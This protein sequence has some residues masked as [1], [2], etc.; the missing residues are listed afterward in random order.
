MAGNNHDS[1]D[2]LPEPTYDEVEASL[3]PRKRKRKPLTPTRRREGFAI[4][5]KKFLLGISAAV[6]AF[7]L[8]CSGI[9]YYLSEPRCTENPEEVLALQS[10]ILHL[11][12]LPGHQPMS[13]CRHSSW[14]RK[15]KVVGFGKKSI[16]IN[17]LM[18]IET[19][20]PKVTDTDLDEAFARNTAK[21]GPDQPEF[22]ETKLIMIEGQQRSFQF[23]KQMTKTGP[24]T[25]VPT[26]TVYGIVFSKSG[27]ATLYL[28]VPESE[29][30]EA[31]V[32]RMLES[33][34]R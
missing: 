18:I 30:D 3:G 21:S 12:P 33:I 17:S 25:E 28:T 11:D 1:D 24:G 22:S 14:G 26:W 34:H 10:E 9:A 29:Y 6:V 5:S 27:T 16:L 13:A 20:H 15:I 31:A 32:I 19:Q 8:L 23:S 2:S 7:L 4:G